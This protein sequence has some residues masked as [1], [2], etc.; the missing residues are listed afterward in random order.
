[1]GS[2]ITYLI[3]AAILVVA[4]LVYFKIADRCNIIDKPN[5]RSSHSSV[6][7][8]G[9]GV[10]FAFSMIVWTVI[11]A[12][13]GNDITRLAIP[14]QASADFQSQ[15]L[16][17]CAFAIGQHSVGGAVLCHGADV[18]I[19]QSPDLMTG[20]QRCWLLQLGVV[21]LMFVGVTFDITLW[22]Y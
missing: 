7:L 8:R 11:M 13:Q 22:M 4:E 9:G 3:T 21:T 16:G 14:L 20:F 10:I 6:V 5:E 18:K 2:W 15:L 19:V 12:I 17:Q 1:M